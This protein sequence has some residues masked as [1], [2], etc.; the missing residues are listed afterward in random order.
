MLSSR[1]PRL[2]RRQGQLALGW[3]GSLG[4]LLQGTPDPEG[5]KVPWGQAEPWHECGSTGVSGG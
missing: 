3:T 1:A 5:I 4:E 2:I